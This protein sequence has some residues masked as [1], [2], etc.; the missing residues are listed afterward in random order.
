MY[1]LPFR[2]LL[3]ESLHLNNTKACWSTCQQLIP[4]LVITIL[5]GLLKL[6]SLKKTKFIS[7]ILTLLYLA[8]SNEDKLFLTWDNSLLTIPPT[9]ISSTKLFLA[10]ATFA[11]VEE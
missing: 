8:C 7:A 6:Q 9:A 11:C 3:N 10:S 2:L 4:D 5:L 1:Y